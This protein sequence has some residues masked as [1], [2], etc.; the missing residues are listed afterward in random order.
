M[1]ILRIAVIPDHRFLWWTCSLCLFLSA[2]PSVSV[3]LQW[4]DS[5]VVPLPSPCGRVVGQVA[6][7]PSL[8]NQSVW[9]VQTSLA[10]Y[11][12]FA[13][14]SASL[15]VMYVQG[16]ILW[17]CGVCVQ[18]N[19]LSQTRTHN[20]VWQLLCC[21]IVPAHGSISASDLIPAINKERLHPIGREKRKK[22]SV[23]CRWTIND[24]HPIYQTEPLY[25]CLSDCVCELVFVS[26]QSMF[27]ILFIR[28]W[29]WF[30][31]RGNTLC[32]WVFTQCVCVCVSEMDGRTVEA[33]MKGR[34]NFMAGFTADRDYGA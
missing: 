7:A 34:E 17:Y 14:V 10:L 16:Y 4:S 13:C 24:S 31:L 12:L 22:Y 9:L 3:D 15:L 11:M 25:V 19:S 1:D 26:V 23:G 20:T 29:A 33:Q 32:L 28:V 18:Q 21:C 2:C 6:L 27:F 8:I 30:S 5:A